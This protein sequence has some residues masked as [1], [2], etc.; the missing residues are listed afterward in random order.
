LTVEGFCIAC[1]QEDQTFPRPSQIDLPVKEQ[2]T[3]TTTPAIQ[4]EK[5]V[6]T[7]NK[8]ERCKSI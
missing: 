2:Q 7:L 3:E 4:I 6:P 8:S 5:P 1:F